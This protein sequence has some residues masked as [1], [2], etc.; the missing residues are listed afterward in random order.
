[1]QNSSYLKA[2]LEA[3]TTKNSTE[4][5]FLQTVKEVLTSLEKVVIKNEDYYK[6]L[7]LLER[8][9]EPERIIS[10]KEE[11]AFRCYFFNSVKAF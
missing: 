8:L 11:S 7:S 3:A 10:F 1:M 9:V 2:V 6:S 4:P 5:E